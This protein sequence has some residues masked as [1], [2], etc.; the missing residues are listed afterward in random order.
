[1]YNT[2]GEQSDRELSKRISQDHD[3]CNQIQYGIAQHAGHTRF[4]RHRSI[5]YTN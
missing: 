5:A 2:K 3:L 4:A 1:M